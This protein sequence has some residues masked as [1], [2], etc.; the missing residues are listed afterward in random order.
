MGTK[1]TFYKKLFAIVIPIAFQQFMLALVTA[2]DSLMLGKVSQDALSAVSLAGQISFVEN[3]F[4]L[5]MGIGFSTLAAQY[6]G[7]ED[8][9]TVE[10]L[11]AYVVKATVGIASV[12]FLAGL[13]FP[14]FLMGLFTRDS[15]LI[16]KGAVY[17]RTVAP[18][19]LL[20]GISQMFLCSLK[21]TGRAG[22][23]GL[24]S[25]VCLCLNILLNAILIF[26]LWGMPRLEIAGAAIATVV[27]RALEMLW[28]GWESVC[29]DGARLRV[30]YIKRNDALLKKDFWQYAVPILGNQLVWGV[31]FTMYSVIMGHLG[32]DAV[33]ANAVSD[34]AKNLIICFSLGIANGAGIL[35]GNELGANRLETAKAY[36]KRL[37]NLALVSGVCSAVLLLAVSPFLFR[38]VSISET[39]AGYLQAMLLM[40]TYNLIAKSVNCTAILGIL[41]AGGDARFGIRCDFTF[42]WCLTVPLGLLAAFVFHLPVLW[43]YFIVNLDEVLKL[44]AVAR[45][46]RSYVW[47]RNLTR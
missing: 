17:L 36:G 46:V 40:C 34:I 23:V 32:S 7:K 42:M 11:F 35:V 15:V 13:F 45:R 33:A 18:A 31:G 16:A 4:L 6:W 3:L 47:V 43:V 12:F 29:K 19:Y 21:N 25:S 20:T 44:F 37:C 9:D 22:K 39:A 10:K 2:S 14:K 28:S 26:G 41:C 27:T 8:K 5:A 24:I 1:V 38:F 30:R